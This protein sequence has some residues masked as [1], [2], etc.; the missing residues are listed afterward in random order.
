VRGR[1]FSDDDSAGAPRVAVVNESTARQLFDGEDPVGRVIDLVRGGAPWLNRPAVL[2]P[3]VIVGV[4]ANVKNVGINEVEFG[5]VYLPFAQAPHTRIEIVARAGTPPAGLVESLRKTAAAVD[6]AVPVTSAGTLDARVSAV[7]Q[8]DR[9]NVLLISGF[10]AVAL[11]LAGVGVYGS[12]AYHVQARTREL[13]VRLALGARPARLVGAAL[14]AAA[15][16][17]ATGGAVGLAATLG[18]ARIIG[19]ALY[20][21]PGSHN[22]LLYGVTT[23]DPQA[24]AAACVGML[25][26]VVGAGAIPARRVARVDP[27]LALRNE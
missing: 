23:T 8:Q 2:G 27:V 14:W 24:L 11:L 17:G 20:L 9:F 6:P 15:R 22:G 25:V 12:V 16:I 13:G 3:H 4:A 10:A 5:N 1:E 26:L 7:L 19:N 18:L 21:V